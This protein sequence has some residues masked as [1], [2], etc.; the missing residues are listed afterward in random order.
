MPLRIAFL[1]CGFITGVHSRQLR[2]L[3]GDITCAYASRDR[4]K[5]EEFN[6][7]YG[8]V[9]SYGSYDEAI[10]DAK[11]DADYTMPGDGDGKVKEILTDLIASEYSG[12][13]SI[14]PHIAVVFH[15]STVKASDEDMFNTFVE[16]GRKLMLLCDSIEVELKLPQERARARLMAVGSYE[17]IARA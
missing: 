16:Y 11:N 1:G 7:R 17:G 5:A 12:G 13:I 2:A 10:D 4:A 9:G 15:D 14:E 3:R 8:G 6:R